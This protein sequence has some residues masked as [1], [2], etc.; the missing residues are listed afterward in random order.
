MGA[1]KFDPKK[2]DR[3]ND[4]SRLALLYLDAVIQRFRL[5]EATV[6][7]DLGTG[8]GLYAEALLHRLPDARC[9]ALDIEPR[10]LD[11]IRDNRPLAA[12][13]RLVPTLMQESAMPLEPDSVDFLFMISLHHE[14]DAPEALL[15]DCRRVLR[16]G[17][18]LLVAD[19]DP[20]R[21][22]DG[23]G[24]PKDHLLAPTVA[25]DQLVEAGFE[26]VQ[27]FEAS[28]RYYCLEAWNSA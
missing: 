23:Q 9:H 27:F 17:G 1:H 22:V 13:G 18:G 3:L 19:W 10:F 20:D 15:A 2:L 7:A 26:S 5:A 28:P 12:A 25:R 6:L 11:W 24:P 16:P 14:L 21:M 4:P 8:T